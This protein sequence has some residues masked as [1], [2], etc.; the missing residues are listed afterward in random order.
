MG[1]V[2]EFL[3]EGTKYLTGLEE[4]VLRNIAATKKLS[5]ITRKAIKRRKKKKKDKKNQMHI[6]LMILS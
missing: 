4:A 5:N 2:Q 3:K 1:S 6:D